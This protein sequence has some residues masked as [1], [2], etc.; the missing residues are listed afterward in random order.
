MREI[1]CKLDDS[2][3]G[4]T[5]AMTIGWL[6]LLSLGWLVTLDWRSLTGIWIA[7]AILARTF[8]HT[9]L[10]I[11]AHDAMHR[12]LI[13]TAPRW[14][15]RLGTIAL[16]CYACLPYHLCRIDHAKHHRYSGQ[17]GNDPD[18]HDGI[19][20][21]PWQW[22]LKFM[23]EY[24]SVRQWVV[25]LSAVA[26]VLSIACCCQISPLAL[27]WW[28]ILPLALSS[29]QLFVFG[30]YL[31][32]SHAAADDRHRART[33]DRPW[34]WSFLSCYHFGYHWEHHEYPQTP[35]YRLPALYSTRRSADRTM[36]SPA[37]SE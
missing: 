7:I 15:D 5:I 8:L 10:F 30:T 17:V 27:L 36:Y 16:W 33:I 12:S 29:I 14:N 25:F 34:W 11:I 1:D 19:H 23:R 21:Q 2:K 9:G 18:F 20:A 6:W 35:W 22:Y 37:K 32:H 13:P 31:P 28:W 3:I 4:T 24:L 26:I